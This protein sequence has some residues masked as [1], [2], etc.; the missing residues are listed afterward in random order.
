MKPYRGRFPEC[1]LCRHYSRKAPAR[2]CFQCGS[3]E[4][5]ED[6]TEQTELDEHAL[7]KMYSEMDRDEH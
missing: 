2:V 3:G 7:M 1:V 5:F 4:F 6:K